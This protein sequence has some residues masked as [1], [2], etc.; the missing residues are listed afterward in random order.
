MDV[1]VRMMMFVFSHGLGAL[2]MDR[3]VKS[4]LVIDGTHGR[5]PCSHHLSIYRISTTMNIY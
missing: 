2:A 3:W 4:Q 5:I 1:N